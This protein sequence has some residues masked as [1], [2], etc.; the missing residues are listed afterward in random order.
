MPPYYYM[1]H[2]ILIACGQEEWETADTYRYAAEVAYAEAHG[3]AKRHDDADSLEVL[4]EI[5]DDLDELI[6]RFTSTA[7]TSTT[8]T[9]IS[10]KTMK[11]S[12]KWRISM[13]LEKQRKLTR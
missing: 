8:W 7:M 10:W 11:F 2:M 13:I 5:R 3:K 9:T 6:D 12:Q 1:K 4:E